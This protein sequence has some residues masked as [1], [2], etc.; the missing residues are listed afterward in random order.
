MMYAKT[1]I[2]QEFHLFIARLPDIFSESGP[3]QMLIAHEELWTALSDCHFPE[4]HGC[5][6]CFFPRMYKDHD[7]MTLLDKRQNFLEG[8]EV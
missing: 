1:I 6:D 7:L 5:L 3:V 4:R 8:H 2:K